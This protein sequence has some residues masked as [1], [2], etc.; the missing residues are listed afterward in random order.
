MAVQRSQGLMIKALTL[1]WSA[2][3]PNV[4]TGRMREGRIEQ[5]DFMDYTGIPDNVFDA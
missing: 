4:K 1:T 5:A 2:D 3:R